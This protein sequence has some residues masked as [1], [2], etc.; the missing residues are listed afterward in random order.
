M[1]MDSPGQTG[2]DAQPMPMR[3]AI[4]GCGPKGLY[5]L[6]SLCTLTGREAHPPSFDVTIYEPTGH[7]GAGAIYDPS[8]PDFLRMNFASRFID[9]WDRTISQAAVNRCSL[10]EWL[11]RHWPEEADPG[12]FVPRATVG[13]Y[14]GECLVEAMAGRPDSIRIRFCFEPVRL[15]ERQR[16][17][18]R[19]TSPTDTEFFD[20][21]LITTGHQDWQRQNRTADR[22]SDAASITSIFPV[23]QRLDMDAVPPGSVVGFKGFALTWIDAALALTVGRGGSFSGQDGVPRYRPSDREPDRLL[24]LSRTGR[25]MLCKPDYR[26]FSSPAPE[27]LWEERSLAILQSVERAGSICFRTAIWPEI[28]RGAD[29]VLG[30]AAGTAQTWFD[31]WCRHPFDGAMARRAMR[32]SYQV[33]TGHAA[34]DIPWA[35]GEAWRRT[36]PAVVDCVSHGGPSETSWHEFTVV[37]REMERIACGPPAVNMGCMLALIDAG[38]VDLSHVGHFAGAAKGAWPRAVDIRVDATLP[39]PWLFDHSGPI[40]GLLHDGHVERGLGGG[41]VIDA[42]GQA[43]VAGIPTPGLSVLGRPTEG[44]VLGNDTLNRVLHRHPV[45]WAERMLGLARSGAHHQ[46]QCLPVSA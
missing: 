18:W 34:A 25:P 33:A 30:V 41:L 26:T 42:S 13:R 36:Y 43:L 9:G 6:E 12:G 45:N 20:E 10:V 16:D 32:S 23:A 29:E 39:P 46:L 38:L 5:A 7:P 2:L 4:V 11:Q 44:C 3:I 27:G 37:A 1:T 14:L 24:P 8:Q 40:G 28:L 21:V 17:L 22:A 15:I 19:V 35:L 31:A